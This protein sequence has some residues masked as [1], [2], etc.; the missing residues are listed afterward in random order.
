MYLLSY[1]SKTFSCKIQ[2]LLFST[3]FFLTTKKSNKKSRPLVINCRKFFHNG[4][5]NINSSSVRKTLTD[6]SNSIFLLNAIAQ[7]FFSAI[8][9]RRVI[10][11]KLRIKIILG[12]SFIFQLIKSIFK[13]I[14]N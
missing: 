6:S 5:K 9:Q 12:V 10:L 13:Y 2:D 1:P 7:N 3:Y 14:L 11:Y 8:Y 4:G